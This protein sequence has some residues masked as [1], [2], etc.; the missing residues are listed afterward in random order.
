[1]LANEY[2]IDESTRSGFQGATS[3]VV[4]GTS[5]SYTHDV[6][7]QRYYYRVRAHNSEGT[8]D[9]YSQYS[10]PISVLISSVV[11]PKTRVLAV[12][13]SLPGALGS[14]FRT[15]LA[16]FN[17]KESS[18][19]GKIVFHP[20]GVSGSASDPSLPYS[21]APRK[22]LSFADLLPA[23][24]VSSGIGSADLVADATSAFPVVLARV[25][26]DAGEDGTAAFA[27]ELLETQDALTAGSSGTLIA[28]SDIQKLRLN[29]GVRTLEAGAAMTITVR[30]S[31]GV[32][33]KTVT[34]S[35]GP[36]Y[37]IQEPSAVLL[38]GFTFTGGETLTFAVT[39]GSAFVYGATTD[40]T[41]N[42]PS[43]Q[44]ARRIE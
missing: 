4:N 34:K 27:G 15:S 39:G 35:Y 23:M 8:C 1:M 13:G 16:L 32:I 42:D 26:D 17:P 40:N 20:A 21:I 33:V 19:S 5:A 7:G 30:D 36:T 18:I 38:D 3:R 43:V 14:N 28:P 6:A 41:T 10:A 44:F 22:T 11:A 9:V 25:F 2:Q 29:I 12:V 37:F 31:S 24:N